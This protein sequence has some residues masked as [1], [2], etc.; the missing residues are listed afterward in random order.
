MYKIYVGN[1][2]FKTTEDSVRSLFAPYS[3]KPEII[4]VKDAET[5]KSRGFA[6]VLVADEIEAKAAMSKLNGSRLDG[7]LLMVGPAGKKGAARPG[8]GQGPFG[9]GGRRPGGAPHRP[10]HRPGRSFRR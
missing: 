10:S 3:S 5:G 4:M 7:R 2:S 1:L 8:P 9:P 6:F